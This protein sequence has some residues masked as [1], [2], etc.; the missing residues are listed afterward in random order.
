MASRLLVA[1]GSVAESAEQ[2]PESVRALL[3][4]AEAILVVSPT[5]PD[6]FHWLSSDTDKARMM[7]D[8][9]LHTL[10]GHI[11]MLG[12]KAEG[13]IGTDDPLLAFDDA[14]AE[15]EADHILIA[16]RSPTQSG[17]QEHHLIERVLETFRLP[18]TVFLLGDPG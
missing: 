10:L 2:L 8:D 4:E 11:E 14:L 1:A 13:E 17:W 7:A 9:R 15:F 12:R 5:L 3:A 6:R 18:V 16:L